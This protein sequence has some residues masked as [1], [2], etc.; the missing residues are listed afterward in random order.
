[1]I[2][3]AALALL[4]TGAAAEPTHL[5]IRAQ[6][7]DAKFIGDQMGGVQVTLSD[8][9]TGRVLAR[10]VTQGATGDTGRIMRTPRARG[11]QL[12]EAS[13]AGF[14]AVVD[15]DS[16]TLVQAE[17]I[18]PAGKAASKIRV[19]SQLWVLPGRDVAGDGW[20]LSFPGLVIEP[21]LAQL[22]ANAPKLSAKISLMCGCP[23]EPGGLWNAENY[24]VEAQLLRGNAIIARTP[25]TYAGKA[26][27]FA[28]S[29]PQAARPGRYR[30]RVIAS[31]KITPNAGVWEAPV[32]VR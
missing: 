19:T 13:T 25:L 26:S 2:I 4:S 10:G 12:T 28:G 31:D 6:A 18:G 32:Q 3:V 15:I 7:M 21:D 5:M 14:D 22:S 11:T 24:V 20:V 16:P 17:A 1:M 30:L 29:F 8:A 23:I 27:L 9:R